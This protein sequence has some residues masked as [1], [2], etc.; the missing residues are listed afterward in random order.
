MVQYARSALDVA[1]KM[2]GPLARSCPAV[3]KEGAKKHQAKHL[4]V[5]RTVQA[6]FRMNKCFNF[7]LL[8]VFF[9]FVPGQL[10]FLLCRRRQM[11][12]QQNLQKKVQKRWS[13]DHHPKRAW[14]IRRFG[15]LADDVHV[16]V[17][18]HFVQRFRIGTCGERGLSRLLSS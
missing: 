10:H 5:R 1:L 4:S 18:W 3:A 16:H 17:L 14:P 7:L 9:L 8:L 11:D 6:E 12:V 15:V 2:V 13:I